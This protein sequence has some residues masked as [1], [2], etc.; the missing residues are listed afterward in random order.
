VRKA[1]S[2]RPKT[3][4]PTPVSVEIGDGAPRLADLV[5]VEVMISEQVPDR[6]DLK[7]AIAQA[8]FDL[9]PEAGTWRVV[10]EHLR[11]DPDSA[12]SPVTAHFG[13]F[14]LVRR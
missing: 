14:F 7:S 13:L 4:A 5:R 1:R 3:D 10:G 11:P 2:E 12:F 6:P 8:A 9:R